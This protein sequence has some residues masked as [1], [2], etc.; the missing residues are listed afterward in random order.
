M[1]DMDGTRWTRENEREGEGEGAGKEGRGGLVGGSVARSALLFC[2]M[3]FVPGTQRLQLR[4]S[5][6]S[7]GPMMDMIIGSAPPS[8]EQLAARSGWG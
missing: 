8:R 2:E 6:V 5:W 4:Q 1:G 7:R 3:R